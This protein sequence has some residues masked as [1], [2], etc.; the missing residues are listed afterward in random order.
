MNGEEIIAPYFEFSDE[1][2]VKNKTFGKNLK[3]KECERLWKKY[4]V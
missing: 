1:K 3:T 4:I 2:E